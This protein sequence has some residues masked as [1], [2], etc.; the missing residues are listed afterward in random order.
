MGGVLSGESNQI[1]K[2]TQTTWKTTRDNGS[3]ETKGTKGETKKAENKF[4]CLEGRQTG[5]RGTRKIFSNR[6]KT[7]ENFSN[8]WKNGFPAG[9]LQIVPIPG[10]REGRR[11]FLLDSL[12]DGHL[13]SSK[14]SGEERKDFLHRDGAGGL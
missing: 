13:L 2:T 1:N 9:G 6:W 7:G 10:V 8:H 5:Q 4:V 12:S 3:W 11:A 14:Q